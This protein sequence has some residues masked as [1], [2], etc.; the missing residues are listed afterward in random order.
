MHGS[1]A[2]LSLV[3]KVCTILALVPRH[4]LPVAL[5]SHVCPAQGAAI[6]IATPWSE[7]TSTMRL[8]VGVLLPPHDL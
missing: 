4:G 2:F 1:F 8:L 7:F 6:F 3:P 5:Y